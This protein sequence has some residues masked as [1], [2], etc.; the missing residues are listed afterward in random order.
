VAGLAALIA[1]VVF[2]PSLIAKFLDRN[3]SDP[4]N[5]ARI[6]IWKSS[7]DVIAQ[8]PMLGV[9]FG[10]FVHVSKRFTFPVEGRVARY[11]KRI[12][13]A[14]SEY[15]QHVAELGIPAALLL[16]GLLG[17]LIY[18]AWK[19]S[20]MAWPENRCFHEAAIFTAVGVGSPAL[21]DNFW[22]IPVNASP[23]VVI[24]LV[25][26]HALSLRVEQSRWAHL[27]L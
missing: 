12:G 24:S 2:S 7:L 14:H 13:I 1:V 18:I 17:Y 4:Y 15:L 16:F 5:Y 25:D 23:R 11:L 6:G 9:G 21:G 3:Q 27:P 20:R 22:I 8:R 26:P 10:Q 19:R